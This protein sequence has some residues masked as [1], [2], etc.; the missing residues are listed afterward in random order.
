[1]PGHS[2]SKNGVVTLAYVPGISIRLARRC[3][4]N[5]DCRV[6]P[7]NDEIANGM[8]PSSLLNSP[9]ERALL[10]SQYAREWGGCV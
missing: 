7:G 6:K 2:R 3:H 5:R 9:H 8:L 1:M 4:R 10:R